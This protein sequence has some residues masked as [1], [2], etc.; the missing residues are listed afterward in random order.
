MQTHQS[1]AVDYRVSDDKC[2]IS[3][4][5]SVDD[6]LVELA[7]VLNAAAREAPCLSDADCARHFLDVAADAHQHG[8]CQFA[9]HFLEIARELC[10]P[11]SIEPAI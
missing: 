9:E 4:A 5:Q 7:A 1:N 3:L 8:D 10:E 11:A 2:R 6:S